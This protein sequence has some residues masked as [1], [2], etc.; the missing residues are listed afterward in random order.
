MGTILTLKINKVILLFTLIVLSLISC[1][2]IPISE[3]NPD[4]AKDRVSFEDLDNYKNALKAI[5]KG[6]LDLAETLLN[7]FT[8]IYPEL[9]GA[10]ANLGLI[11]YKKNKLIKSK[12]YVNKAVNLNSINPYARN[13]LGMIE[14]KNGNFKK[15]ETHYL[16]AIKN[17]S[18]YANA[19]YNIALLYDIYFQEIRKSIVHYRKYLKLIK[20]KG[21]KDKKTIDWVEQLVN[22]IKKG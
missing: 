18:N 6:K 10:W 14:T 5:K 16:L 12:E 20:K 11:Y 8:T 4:N 7:D 9:A 21:R 1:T 17:K 2:Q 3:I 19:H 22:S 15:A 13:L